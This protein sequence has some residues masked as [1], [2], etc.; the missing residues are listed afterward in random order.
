MNRDEAWALLN[1]FTKSDSLIRHALAVEAGMRAYAE[2]F[3]EDVEKWGIAG[4]L[5]DFDY[6]MYPDNHP[7]AGEPILRERGCPEDVIYAIQGHASRE[8]F[9]REHLLD[10]V[11]YAVDELAGFIVAVTLVIPSKSFKDVKVKSVKKKLKDK[12]FARKVHRE[13]IYQGV[14]ELGIPLEEHIAFLIEALAK[15]EE[16][17]N[18]HGLSIL[19]P[20]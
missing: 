8:G 15:R 2:K 20:K 12:A 6:E 17:L 10:K 5:H 1:E 9:P 13:E 3:G 18:S 19:P 11:L 7:A 4:L 14:E 16:E